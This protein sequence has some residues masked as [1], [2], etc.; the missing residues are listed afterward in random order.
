MPN[1]ARVHDG[2]GR[3][4]ADYGYLQKI[5]LI[6]SVFFLIAIKK[7]KKTVSRRNTGSSDSRV[8]MGL[9]RDT[10]KRTRD[11]IVGLAKLQS[12][13]WWCKFDGLV[14]PR[15]SASGV[16]TRIIYW[17]H[18]FEWFNRNA[19]VAYSIRGC[20]ASEKLV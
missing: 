6:K 5:Y 12:T 1:T 4:S 3:S 14:R 8:G 17:F 18:T 7:L 20:A 2:Q 9:F 11:P 19:L 16:A 13:R 15:D 10:D